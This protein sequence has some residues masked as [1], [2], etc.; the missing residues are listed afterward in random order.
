MSGQAMTLGS[1]TPGCTGH[2]CI[3]CGK[4]LLI[5]PTDTEAQEDLGETREQLSECV[6]CQMANGHEPWGSDGA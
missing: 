2:H 5:D 6:E 3:G 1:H 4:C